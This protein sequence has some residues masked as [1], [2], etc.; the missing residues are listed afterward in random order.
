VFKTLFEYAKEQNIFFSEK[1]LFII[2]NRVHIYHAIYGYELYKL[3]STI[4]LL[5]STLAFSLETL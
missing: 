3:S 2:S 4:N 5:D 1:E